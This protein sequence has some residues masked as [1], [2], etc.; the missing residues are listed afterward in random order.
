VIKQLHRQTNISGPLSLE[1]WL[2][3]AR[4]SP[5]PSIDG[6]DGR[7]AARVSGLTLAVRLGSKRT[8][9]HGAYQRDQNV[10]HP[11]RR[12]YDGTLTPRALSG[13]VSPKIRPDVG[14]QVNSARGPGVLHEKIGR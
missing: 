8:P 3:E 1:Y 10:T 11:E 7:F 6:L 2:N 9:C 5:V 14:F 12:G 4:Y 13:R